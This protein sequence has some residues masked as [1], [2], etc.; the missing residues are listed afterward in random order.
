MSKHTHFGY[1]EVPVEKKTEKV[2]EVFHS[3]SE[4]YDLMNDLMSF[5]IHRWWKRFTLDMAAV[6]AG[7]RVLDLASGTGDL[8]IKMAERLQARGEI[9]ITDINSSML[10]IARR[11]MID[12]GLIKNTQYLLVNAE[13][14]PFADNYFDCIT[15]AFGL[16]NV[17]HIDKALAEMRRVVV[18]GGRVLILEFS[19]PQSEFFQKIYDAYSFNVLPLLGKHVAK[20]E[21]SYRYLAESIRMHPDQETLKKMMRDAG[22]DK[23]DVH[24][25]TGGVVAVHR[26]YKW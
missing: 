21:A 2:A 22:F 12:A 13:Q 11:R 4:N 17:T 19:K 26:G 7:E 25:L 9:F 20:D 15:I 1:Q 3:V 6:R 5:G 18:P 14:L 24:N 10:D 23:V 16:R 8:A